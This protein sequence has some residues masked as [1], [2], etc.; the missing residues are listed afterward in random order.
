MHSEDRHSVFSWLT[1]GTPQ[2]HQS[3]SQL[4]CG[5]NDPHL[6]NIRACEDAPLGTLWTHVICLVCSRGKTLI[7][8]PARALLAGDDAPRIPH[9]QTF[10]A[11]STFASEKSGKT[12]GNGFGGYGK[13]YTP[14]EKSIKI[15]SRVGMLITYAPA[16][17]FS[18]W[19]RSQPGS[20]SMKLVQGLLAIQFGKRYPPC[21]ALFLSVASH[22][23]RPL[24]LVLCVHR[25]LRSCTRGLL[26]GK[27]N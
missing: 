9:P 19:S 21:L 20:Q 8:F 17:F 27:R 7:P 15:S 13:F 26:L 6:M 14:Q 23:C 10:G 1:V 5:K 2:N 16:L 18:L 4:R 25:L 3:C 22:I 12:E 11:Y 24:N